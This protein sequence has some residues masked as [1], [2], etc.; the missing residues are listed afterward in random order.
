MTFDN[1]QLRFYNLP[2]SLKLIIA[3]RS[4][5]KKYD[6]SSLV[7]LE[8]LYVLHKSKRTTPDEMKLP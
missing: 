5:A 7:N 3:D 1:R 6:F 8:E 2:T 4:Q